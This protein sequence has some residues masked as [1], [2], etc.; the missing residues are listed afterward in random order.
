MGVATAPDMPTPDLPTEVET[1]APVA[2]RVRAPRLA[3][4]AQWLSSPLNL[5]LALL[6]L[7]PPILIVLFVADRGNNMPY[8]HQW[9]NS[10]LI[11]V[12]A[13]AG[14]LT[15]A[16]VV[17][18]NFDHRLVFANLITLVLTYTT[19]WNLVVEMGLVWLVAVANLGLLLALFRLH[20]PRLLP[21]VLLPFSLLVFA[22]RANSIW[23]WSMLISTPLIIMFLLLALYVLKR[24]PVG[25]RPLLIAA[26]CAVCMS[27]CLLQGFIAWPLLLVALWLYG[28][29]KPAYTLVWLAV[30]AV[31]I[32]LYFSNYDFSLLG[33]NEDG[34]S[35]GLVTNAGKLIGYSLAYLGN[36]FVI[37]SGEWRYLSMALAII[38]LA[39]GALNAVYLW[40]RSRSLADV[41]AWVVLALWACGS[42]LLTAL[43]RSAAYPELLPQQPMIDR[44]VPPPAMFWAAFVALAVLVL[45]RVAQGERGALS[46]LLMVLN[47]VVLATLTPLYGMVNILAL[48]RPSPIPDAAVDCM[49]RFPSVRNTRCFAFTYLKQTP[50]VNVIDR[51]NELSRYQLAAFAGRE[52][53]YIDSIS[54]YRVERETTR[55]GGNVA[56]KFY[57]LSPAQQF[58][59]FQQPAPSQTEFTVDIPTNGATV[60]LA[61]AVTLDTTIVDRPLIGDGV[62]FRVGLRSPSQGTQLIGDIVYDPTV[63]SGLKPFRFN[64][65]AYRGETVEIV[66]Q[67]SNRD[68]ASDDFALW[69]DPIVFVTPE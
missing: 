36:P 2:V 41:T 20:S 39:L 54:L 50:L 35:A 14:T 52:P 59:A 23:L 6:A 67:T 45:W 31:T 69:I 56:F 21:A 28:Y 53:V 22:V 26:L 43:G 19:N 48:D 46:R 27:L 37:T 49:V 18:Q 57:D 60:F 68:D 17:R 4:L 44:Y 61:G 8:L 66:L 1:E 11:A 24:Y 25:W 10:V 7:I 13:A 62:I 47:V 40:L 9:E 64:L 32:L 5:F 65:D 30:T 42:A 34:N 38:G 58:V 15:P 29:R 3:G 33:A 63:D 55:D 16:D 12:K 51:I